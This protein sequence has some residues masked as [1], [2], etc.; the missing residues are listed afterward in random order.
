MIEYLYDAIRAAAGNDIAIQAEIT[1]DNGNNIIEDCYLVLH[2]KDDSMLANISGSYEE[3]IWTFL[4]NA[5]TT[6]DLKGRYMYCIRCANSSL[7][8]KQPIYFE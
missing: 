2:D 6:K 4:I 3:G 7:C 5:E 1:D 8:F